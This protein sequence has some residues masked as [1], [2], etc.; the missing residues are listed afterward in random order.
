[1][2]LSPAARTGVGGTYPAILSD[3]VVVKLFGYIGEWQA[4]W[5]NERFAQARLSLDSRILAPRMV[6]AG[7][8]FPEFAQSL[9]YLILTRIPGRDWED[10]DLSFEERVQVAADLGI[11]LRL[12][13]ALPSDGLPT[14]D[15]WMTRSVSDGA[16]SGR[17]PPALVDQVD[18]WVASIPMD[19]PAFV[20]S[21]IFTRHPYVEHG[22]LTGIIDWGDAMAAD[23][24]VELGKLHL[25]VFAGDKRLLRVFL[26]AYGWPADTGFS[27]KALAM[28]L[29]RHTQILGQHG[30]GGDMFYRVPELIAGAKVETLDELAEALFGVAW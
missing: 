5:D 2:R 9:P 27:R 1:M 30:E 11:Q 14:I 7:Q 24:H 17:F 21:D 16:R 15:S 10:A 28:A 3:E 20:H 29:R 12:I 4:T 19:P 18:R 26:H 6:G 13:H 25:D 22:R 8:L 23:P